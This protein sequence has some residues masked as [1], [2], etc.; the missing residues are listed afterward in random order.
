MSV[1]ATGEERVL[2]TAEGYEDRCRELDRLRTDERRRLSDLLRQARGDGRPDDNPALV[3]LLDEQA[4]LEQRIAM[5][6]AQLAAAEVAPPPSD[7]RAAIGSVVRVRDVATREV[8][9]YR[10]VGPIEGDPANGRLSV[11]AP[12]GSAV[13]GRQ[14]GARVEATTPRGAVTLEVL[15]VAATVPDSGDVQAAA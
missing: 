15:D 9:E 8:L 10:L 2:I 5:V 14:R 13:M 6:E 7:G 12:I 1:P 11:A 3:E 4:Q